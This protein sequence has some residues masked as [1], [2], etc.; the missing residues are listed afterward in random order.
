MADDDHAL[1]ISHPLSLFPIG[2]LSV[3]IGTDDMYSRQN[4]CLY[5]H[6]VSSIYDCLKIRHLVMSSAARYS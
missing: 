2:Y 4:V 3:K 1:L 5:D 6:Y